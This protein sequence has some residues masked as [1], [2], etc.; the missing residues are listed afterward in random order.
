VGCWATDS[1][2]ADNRTVVISPKSFIGFRY[3]A[4]VAGNM[5]GTS[6]HRMRHGGTRKY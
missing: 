3:A 5:A 2:V 1:D 4:M 6:N